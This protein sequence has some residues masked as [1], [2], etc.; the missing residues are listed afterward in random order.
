MQFERPALFWIALAALG[1]LAC[2]EEA[3]TFPGASVIIPAVLPIIGTI[4][5][6]LLP[7]GPPPP[8]LPG[9]SVSHAT[10]VATSVSNQP[11]TISHSGSVSTS[12][13]TNAGAT[14]TTGSG[15]SAQSSSGTSK[16]SATTSTIPGILMSRRWRK[17]FQNLG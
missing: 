3:K 8:S 9:V 7:G 2:G 17:F 16:K 12:G 1:S 11:I 5:P 15:L 6:A 14:A 13:N 4:I 10:S